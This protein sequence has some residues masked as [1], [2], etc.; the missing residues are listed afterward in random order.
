MTV[1]HAQLANHCFEIVFDHVTLP[2][3]DPILVWVFSL[4]CYATFSSLTYG[5]YCQNARKQNQSIAV[6]HETRQ[7]GKQSCPLSSDGFR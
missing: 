2:T 4:L 5:A 7:N 6:S 1:S 3:C